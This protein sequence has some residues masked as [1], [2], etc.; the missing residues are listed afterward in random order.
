MYFDDRCGDLT[1]NRAGRPRELRDIDQPISFARF[2]PDFWLMTAF[3]GKAR[4]RAECPLL[5]HK[6][7]RIYR[8]G[9]SLF[10]KV[11]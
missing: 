7:T 5:G 3:A 9:A 11:Q 2:P 1:E 6:R 10:P 4:L 8:N